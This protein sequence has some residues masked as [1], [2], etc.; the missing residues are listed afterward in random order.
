M[1]RVS[2]LTHFYGFKAVLND[3]NVEIHRGELVAIMGPNGIGKS[4]LL[5]CMAGLLAP[6]DGEVMIDGMVRRSSADTELAIRAK[7]AYLADHPWLPKLSSGREILH[8]VGSIYGIDP[9]PLSKHIERLLALFELKAH[10]DSPL[11]T[12]SNGQRKK[13]AVAAALVTEAPYLLLDE[14]FTG[15]LD[16]S[17]IH[18]LRAVLAELA[19]REDVTVVMASQIPELV[20]MVAHRVLVLDQG[21]VAAFDTVDALKERTGAATFAEALENLV[22]PETAGRID[23][24]FQKEDA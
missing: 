12:Y 7:V 21:K 17:S 20:E 5:S 9:R 18:A 1:I 13:L 10:G 2:H 8:A 15:G 16:P 3:I 22:N 4:T 11:G 19:E 23:Q 24:Y 6:L 14:P